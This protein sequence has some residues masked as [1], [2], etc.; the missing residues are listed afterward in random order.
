MTAMPTVA[1]VQARMGSSRLP[2]KVLHTFAGKTALAHCLERTRAC[3]AIDEVVV[4]TTTDPRDDVLVEACRAGGWRW[5]RGSEDDVLDRYYHAA[6][7][8]GATDVV[9]ITSDCPLTDPAV[10]GDV[11]AHFRATR[12]DYASTSLPAPT[13]PIGVSVEVVR[14]DVLAQ[15]WRDDT[16]PAWREHVTPFVYRH[17]ERFALV[18]H[19]AGADYSHHRWTLDTPEDAELL[20]RI[21]DALPAGSTSW[22]DA[23]AVVDA[24]PEWAGI[25]ATIA[26]RTV[27]T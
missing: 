9:R 10:I 20:R 24:H 17:P 2:G 12:A 13:F 16:N 22:R 27:P 6:R 11:L 14:F 26:Q 3:P 18:G 5:H 4:A 23:L 21:F 25:N 19:G 15:A 8:A 7:A 1:I